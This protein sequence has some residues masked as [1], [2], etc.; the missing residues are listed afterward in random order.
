MSSPARA[1]AWL[2]PRSAAPPSPRPRSAWVAI[3]EAH[4]FG[5]WSRRYQGEPGDQPND[6]DVVL[7]TSEP[8][9]TGRV[10][11]FQ[12]ELQDRIHMP[13]DAFAVFPEDWSAPKDEALRA[14]QNGPTVSVLRLTDATATDERRRPAT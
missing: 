11:R 1:I 13:V 3:D 4:V 12:R 9:P 10:L 2:H 14:V 6:L 7:V 8:M 5:T